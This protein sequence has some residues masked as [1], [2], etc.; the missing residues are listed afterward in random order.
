MIKVWHVALRE[1]WTT[2]TTKGFFIAIFIVP[3][4]TGCVLLLLRVFGADQPPVVGG[5]IVL[6]DPAGEVS[7]RARGRLESRAPAETGLALRLVNGSVTELEQ[8]KQA[9]VAGGTLLAV[10]V[11]DADAVEG[12]GARGGYGTYRLFVRNKLDD[13]VQEIIDAVLSEVIVEARAEKHGLDARALRE[14][15]TV[16]PHAART[17]TKGGEHGAT[18]AFQIALPA[19]FTLLLFMAVLVSGQSLM[20]TTIEEKSSRVMEVLLSA[21]SPLELLTGK[22]LGQLAVGLLVLGAY[23]AIGIFGLARYELL[24]LLDPVLVGYLLVFFLIAYFIVASV[25][26]AIGGAVSDLRDAQGLLTPVMVVLMLPWILWVPISREPN[27]TLSVVLSFLPPIN[28]FAMLLRVAST[29]PPPSWQIWLSVVVGIA[30]VAVALWF[31]AKV[32]RIGLLLHG[33]PPTFATLFRW[34]R[35]P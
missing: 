30:S 12:R 5:E 8:R 1:F 14:L 26:A 2:V 4:L 20:S 24:A 10:A 16:S 32:F 18:A 34:L 35:A 25:M 33:K 7:E 17:V 22:I 11:I 19:V 15:V 13:R 6:I 27:S 28:S 3:V 9:L 21:V 29:S 31:A 23:G